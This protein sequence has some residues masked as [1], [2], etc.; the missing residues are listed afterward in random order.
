MMQKHKQLPSQLLE[1]RWISKWDKNSDRNSF[2]SHISHIS[3]LKKEKKKKRENEKGV[4]WYPSLKE[5]SNSREEV[6]R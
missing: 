4:F 5:V 2:L 3:Y 6:L 1:K